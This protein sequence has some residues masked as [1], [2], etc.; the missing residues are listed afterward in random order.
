MAVPIEEQ[1]NKCGGETKGEEREKLMRCCNEAS[2]GLND[3]MD[4]AKLTSHAQWMI[5]VVVDF[6]S[7]NVSEDSPREWSE[8]SD[9][10]GRILSEC[11][12]CA[13]LRIV[14]ASRSRA[15]GV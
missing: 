1:N 12:A 6:I 4:K 5:C 7:S 10:R 9:D 11:I 14:R 2:C 15:C 8:R 13:R 3:S